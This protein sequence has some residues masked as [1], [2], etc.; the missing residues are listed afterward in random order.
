MDTFD[1]IQL[2]QL[3][4]ST[5]GPHVSVFLPA[6]Q[7]PME[8]KEDAVRVSN[9]ARDAI[10]RL[11]ENWM[12]E[13]EGEDFVKPLRD[14][15]EDE[16]FLADR[17]HGVAI[18]LSEACF[19]IYQ[20]DNSAGPQL[21]V[22]RI[23]H[24]RPLLSA[25]NEQLAFAVLRLSK[26]GVSLFT[27]TPSGVSELDLQGL[28]ESFEASLAGTSAD[29][30]S[31]TH[32]AANSSG[33]AGKQA[34]VFHGQ[35]GIP[36][37]EKAELTDYLHHVDKAVCS[38]L[39]KRHDWLVLSG[40][41]YETAIYRNLSSYPRITSGSIS[42]NMDHL[43]PEQLIELATPI[44]TAAIANEREAEAEQI[45]ERRHQ[46][47]A[48]DPEKVLTAACRGQV[49]TLFID[50]NATLSGSFHPETAVLKE[51][52]D[53]PTGEPGDP[54]HDLIELAAVQTLMHGGRVYSVS[55]S[56]MPVDA[57]MVAALRY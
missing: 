37:A 23:F 13:L 28:P 53:E 14:L 20:L 55:A 5:G 2:D 16:G 25:L 29:R 56:E 39:A 6:P 3:L 40:V 52:H 4:A 33:P 24:V 46:A 9:L 57:R 22:D 38:A 18:Y 27:A 43:S 54:S 19:K 34:A 15:A 44:A 1:R 8:A 21:W 32:S 10:A 45:R 51:L 41:D 31:Q 42:G 47:V 12:P 11:K 48:A 36:D 35:G 7:R 50:Q 49:K 26:K 30:G 17:R